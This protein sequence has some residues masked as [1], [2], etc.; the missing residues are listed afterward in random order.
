MGSWILS[1]ALTENRGYKYKGGLGTLLK[2]MLEDF[3]EG[4]KTPFEN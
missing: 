4:V 3:K 2:I 1:C